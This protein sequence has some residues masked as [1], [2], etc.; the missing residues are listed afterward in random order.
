M[1][2]LSP[3]HLA[4]LA[5]IAGNFL[6]SLSDVAVKMLDGDVSA[7]QYVF[8]R[9]LLATLVALP[10]YLKT[11]LKNSNI[12]DKENGKINWKVTLV[13][14]HLVI[15]GA[16]SMVVAI[17]YLPLA[18]ANA[19]FYAAPILMLPLSVLILKEKLSTAKVILTIVGFIGVLVVLRP[20]QFHWALSFALL[21]ALTLA[22]YQILVR[23]LPLDQSVSHTLFWTSLA[24]LPVSG[25]LAYTNWQPITVTQLG[26]IVASSFCILSYSGLAVYAYKLAQADQIALSEYSGLIFVTIFGVIWFSEIPDLIT[27]CGIALIIAPMLPLKVL[28]TFSIPKKELS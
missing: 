16:C 2:T 4:L 19:V 17:T 15:V 28:R 14:A 6:A 18:T 3:T 23:K 22:L 1:Y 24:S 21:T 8:L 26:W 9:Q 7:Y 12:G 11:R 13:R 5:L 25:I 10:F 27:L 20:S